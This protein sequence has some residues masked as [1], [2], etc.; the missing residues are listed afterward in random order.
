VFP[1][2]YNEFKTAVFSS[3]FLWNIR[4]KAPKEQ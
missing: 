1:F 4:L 3:V 2:K